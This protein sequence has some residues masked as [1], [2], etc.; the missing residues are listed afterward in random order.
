MSGQKAVAALWTLLA[1]SALAMAQV[2]VVERSGNILLLS[3]GLAPRTLT[4]SGRDADPKLSP[5]GTIVA[6]CRKAE[7]GDSSDTELWDVSTGLPPTE[8]PLSQGELRFRGW[9]VSGCRVPDF[10]PGGRLVYYIAEYAA[11][12]GAIVRVDLTTKQVV[13]V[14]DAIGFHVV[15]KGK[16]AGYIVALKRKLTLVKVWRWYWLLDPDGNEVEAI[17]DEND[18]QMFREMYERE[19]TR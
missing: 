5:S 3:D 17:G 4:R 19:Q 8:E 7:S 14:S 18:L 13:V 6:F 15:Q 11:T 2:E 1:L 10:S 16:Y 12:T 9:A